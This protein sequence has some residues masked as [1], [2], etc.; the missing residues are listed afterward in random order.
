MTANS[1]VVD[2]LG[3]LPGIRRSLWSSLRFA[4]SSGR[5]QFYVVLLGAIAAVAMEFLSVLGL[6]WLNRGPTTTARAA[7]VVLALGL[8]A[9]LE[10]VS[11]TVIQKMQRVYN[12][13]LSVRVESLVAGVM[14]HLPG[15]EHCERPAILDRLAV[16]RYQ[17]FA[18]GM[19]YS[20]LLN[21]ASALLRIILAAL[22]LVTVW[23]PLLLLVPAAAPALLVA[24][25]TGT[26]IRDEQERT[27]FHERLARSYLRL[28]TDPG[29]AKEVR[30]AGTGA[31][32]MASY[33]QH[34]ES[35]NYLVFRARGRAAAAVALA[36]LGF[37]AS[38]GGLLMLGLKSGHLG[39]GQVVVFV[40]VGSRVSS[41][42]SEFVTE[43]SFLRGDWVGVAQRLE[44]LL[45]YGE[46]AS[47]ATQGAVIKSVSSELQLHDVSFRYPGSHEFALRN[48]TLSVAPGE[49]VAVVGENGSGKS[50][51][52]KLMTGM[53]E[54][55]N[56]TIWRGNLPLRKE[57]WAEWR[58]G[59]AATF[60]DFFNFESTLKAAV[61]LGYPS[62]SEADFSRAISD[63]GVVDFLPQ[64]K[65]GESQQL[66]AQW[67]GG[68]NLSRGQWQRI[69]I[70][71]GM[72]HPKPS[73]TLLDEPS[74]A[75]DARAEADL[76]YRY[77]S[78]AERSRAYRSAT[79]I[80]THRFSTVRM[81][82]KIVVMDNGSII[83]SG[84]HEQLMQQ[85]GR[86]ASLYRLQ[87]EGFK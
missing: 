58:S 53:Y 71:R 5:S 47:T 16:L 12:I 46:T 74:A 3:P 75:L 63:S 17:S 48:V 41:Y 34:R 30:V 31:R 32:L 6:A 33:V 35:R 14:A 86:Y 45:E 4:Y 2:S 40:V 60:Q 55:T 67:E 84:S 28:M 19:L 62:A 20:S 42:L 49:V 26:R 1:T 27:S 81:A 85:R 87:S 15:I 10:W 18:L 44:W 56:G 22:L 69:A 51:L 80:I 59:V 61:R 25:R 79:V 78:A 13:R 50:T 23:P 9:G 77:S 64:L 57:N 65:F 73:F 21:T 83:E 70:A 24:A 36:W 54:P 8:L 38:F 68:V 72:L 76:F 52:A 37:G 29:P 43:A 39:S 66:G 7:G 11:R 82:D